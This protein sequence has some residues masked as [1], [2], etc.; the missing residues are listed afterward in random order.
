MALS[1][2]LDLAENNF[3][4]D[5]HVVEHV[6]EVNFSMHKYSHHSQCTTYIALELGRVLNLSED[7]Y[8]N[9][10]VA[11][12]L[13][14]IGAQNMLDKVHNSS[15]YIK[16]HC[17]EGARMIQ[18]TP[19]LI[20]VYDII[21][22]H[23]ENYNGTGC[24]KLKSYLTPFES[25]IIRLADLIE[26]KYDS[27]LQLYPE[28]DNIINWVKSQSEIL[29]N[30]KIVDAFLNIA[31]TDSFWFNLYNVSYRNFLLENIAPINDRF[32]SLKEFET[33]AETFATIIDNKS[34]F[35]A[36][37]SRDIANLAYDVSKYLNYDD[38]KCIK[39]KIS[40]LL[41]DIGKLAIPT[42]ILDK[43]GKL[44]DEEF[45]II[46]SHPYYTKLILDRI[47]NIKDISDWAS[48]H[49]EKLN[50]FGYPR[51]LKSDDIC[52]ES[53]IIGVCDIYQALTEDRPYRKGMYMYEAFQI[54]DDMS[55]NGLVC[56]KAVKYLKNT[57][58]SKVEK[59]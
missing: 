41:H 29:F 47:S 46:K 9:L 58:V 15:E 20:Q 3:M 23:H 53:R 39:M 28:K 36:R 25:Q 44:T 48:N 18:Q 26:V 2:S 54:L 27:N 11:S 51:R 32:L 6:S 50:G 45:S 30:P 12:M 19:S 4:K 40:G 7:S 16:K 22:Y 35:T 37:H 33:I 13:H 59:K 56:D 55:R 38:D 43:N 34:S 5:I 21:L 52:E 14:D 57:L 1:I 10:Y 49:H 31:N 24:M 17:I 8:Y 42:E